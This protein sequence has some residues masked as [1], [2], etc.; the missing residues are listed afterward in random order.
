MAA[1]KNKAEKSGRL[2]LGELRTL[3]ADELRGKLAEGR[4]EL[5]DARLKHAVAQLERTSEIRALRR[6]V[7]RMMTVLN[8]KQQR[9]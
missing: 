8:E 1:K 5:M 2:P 6:Q 4:R 3:N 7:A 9:A